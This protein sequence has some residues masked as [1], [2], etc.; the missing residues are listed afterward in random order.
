MSSAIK[1][2][3]LSL[4]HTHTTFSPLSSSLL[5]NMFHNSHPFFSLSLSSFSLS[6]TS[7][8]SFSLPPST[9]G[10]VGVAFYFDDVSFCFIG[11]HLAAH[12][13]KV[14]SLSCLSAGVLLILPM[15]CL[16]LSLSLSL[17]ALVS[18]LHKVS[19]ARAWLSSRKQVPLSPPH[20]LFIFSGVLTTD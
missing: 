11:S 2:L 9:K 19:L 8:S 1:S 10:G 20:I 5:F 15:H 4:T 16:S 3:S 6:S 17:S 12:Q 14:M 13:E 7:F 18:N